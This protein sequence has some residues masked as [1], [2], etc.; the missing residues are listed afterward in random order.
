MFA[1]P[2]FDVGF[3]R[4]QRARRGTAILMHAL[5]RSVSINLPTLDDASLAHALAARGKAVAKRAQ[6]LHDAIQRPPV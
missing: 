4:R 2:E 1:R 6:A 5:L 3:S